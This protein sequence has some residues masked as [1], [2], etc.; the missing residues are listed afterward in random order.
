MFVLHFV[1]RM[2]LLNNLLSHLEFEDVMRCRQLTLRLHFDIRTV[3]LNYDFQNVL[4]LCDYS[5]PFIGLSKTCFAEHEYSP[6][7]YL[8]PKQFYVTF[9][10]AVH[11]VV[12]DFL[13]MIVFDINLVTI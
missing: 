4:Y 7:M 3:P 10:L 5:L 9:L 13:P 8:L 6:Y 2:V 1:R 12:R 11:I